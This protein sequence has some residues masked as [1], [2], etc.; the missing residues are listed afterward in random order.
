M[1][2]ATAEDRSQDSVNFLFVD[3][4]NCKTCGN[5]NICGHFTSI[6]GLDSRFPF[7]GFLFDETDTLVI[8]RVSLLVP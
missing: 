4:S 6:V 1:Q 3:P 5:C 8:F 7:V 2:G